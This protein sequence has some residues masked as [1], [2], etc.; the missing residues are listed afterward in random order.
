MKASSS[1]HSSQVNVSVCMLREQMHN[2]LQRFDVG[3]MAALA[4]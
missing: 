2:Y 1:Q 3:L 4:Q